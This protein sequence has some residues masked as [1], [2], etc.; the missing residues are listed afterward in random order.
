M[1]A[2]KYLALKKALA[3]HIENYAVL[4]VAV[5]YNFIKL[6][7]SEEEA[8]DRADVLIDIF[9]KLLTSHGYI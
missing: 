4:L 2:N 6:T 1:S 7:K 8:L 5:V 3:P 9:V